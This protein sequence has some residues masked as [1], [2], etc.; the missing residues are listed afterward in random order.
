MEPVKVLYETPREVVKNYEQP[1]QWEFHFLYSGLMSIPL[2]LFK[3]ASMD[4]Q[5]PMT[6]QKYIKTNGL[7]IMDV[8]VHLF[9]GIY[10]CNLV[11]THFHNLPF[12][13][14]VE[15]R[16]LNKEEKKTLKTNKRFILVIYEKVFEYSRTKP[17][18]CKLK[19]I[20]VRDVR[21]F[22]KPPR[23]FPRLVLGYYY[24]FIS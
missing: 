23:Q 14:G 6:L 7:P 24:G 4:T 13:L 3:I 9:R 15:F 19:E 2:G 1:Y 10:T 22:R 11:T 5:G 8:T 18:R 21:Y 16:K 17:D 20:L 12:N